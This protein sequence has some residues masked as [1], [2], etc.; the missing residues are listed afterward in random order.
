MNVLSWLGSGFANQVKSYN[1]SA[2]DAKDLAY[3]PQ[4]SI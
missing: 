1:P 3:D 4:A 2:S